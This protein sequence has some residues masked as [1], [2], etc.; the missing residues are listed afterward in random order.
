M[1]SPP[2]T[3]TWTTPIQDLLT[4]VDEW[5]TRPI[6]SIQTPMETR[7]SLTARKSGRT[8]PHSQD[9][10]EDG[11]EDSWESAHGLDPLAPEDAQ[12]DPDQDGLVN[13]REF[14]LGTKPQNRDTDQDGLFDLE[15]VESPLVNTNPLLRDTDADG[16]PDGW[17]IQYFPDLDPTNPEDGGAD[18]DGDQLINRMEYQLQTDIRNPDTDADGLGDYMEHYVLNT[19]PL[20][21]DSDFDGMPD[22]WEN[23]Q[24]FHPALR[25]RPVHWW[26]MDEGE[27]EVRTDHFGTWP[28]ELVNPSEVG[29][30]EGM[31]GGGFG[32]E[33]WNFTPGILPHH[34]RQ[35]P[36]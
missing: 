18:L 36:L 31:V 29:A 21:P 7:L 16:I 14:E 24:Q 22:L 33:Q 5:P 25:P 30:A 32:I 4:N 35:P 27:G 34:R 17:E 13:L 20:N 11:M 26:R 12:M 28:L 9:S 6:H 2:F 15:E 1:R 19:D 10:D 8:N 3:T 23:E